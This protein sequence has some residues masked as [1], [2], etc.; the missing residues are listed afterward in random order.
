MVE[1]TAVWPSLDIP[2]N[3]LGICGNYWY[4]VENSLFSRVH[5]VIENR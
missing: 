4:Y 3:E 1:K 2:L 5:R